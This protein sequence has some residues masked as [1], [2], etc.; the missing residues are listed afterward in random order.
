[1]TTLQ[2]ETPQD[3]AGTEHAV[4]L[5]HAIAHRVVSELDRVRDTTENAA[6][7]IGELLNNIVEEATRENHEV[8]DTL[9]RIVGSA[10]GT[11]SEDASVTQVI[12]EQSQLVA[13]FVGDTK[14][15]FHRQVEFAEAAVAACEKITA[16]ADAV[17]GLMSKSL[18]LALN[19][20]IEASR[21]GSQA[22]AFNAIGE[23]MKTFAMDVRS[24]NEEIVQ[25]MDSLVKTLP[26]MREETASMETRVGDFSR[27]LQDR[28]T[29]V[30]QH[31]QTLAGSL[32]ANLDHAEERNRQIV[33]YSHATL[34][35]LQFQDP[36]AQCLTRLTVD[37]RNLESLI[38][39]GTCDER[40]AQQ[41]NGE[42]EEEAR[43]AGVVELF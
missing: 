38:T 14:S 37:V 17:S 30:E 9:E 29:H 27:E 22:H 10:D 4:G 23:E 8:C 31:T 3:A 42:C 2:I 7:A 19:M 15:F 26:Q 36:V 13:G 11:E 35:E 40:L 6:L 33:E 21:L 12:R 24:A 20:R 39:T 16:C 18:I 41:D 28:L 25:V 34:S 5:G 32:Q 1:M 43:Q